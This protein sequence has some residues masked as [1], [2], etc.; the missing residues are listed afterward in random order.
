MS[1]NKTAVIKVR[2][3]RKKTK[4]FDKVEFTHL[5]YLKIRKWFIT[6]TFINKFFLNENFDRSEINLLK[7]II[8]QDPIKIHDIILETYSKSLNKNTFIFTLVLLSNGSF[9]SKRIFKSL[10]NKIIISPKELYRFMEF[11]KKE[12]GFGQVIHNAI[13]A[14]FKSYDV[15]NLEKMFIEHRSGYGWK[16]QDVIRLIRP[17]PTDHKERLLYNW[18]ANDNIKDYSIDERSYL[19]YVAAYEN[20]RNNKANEEKILEYIEKLN[21]KNSMIPGNVKRTKAILNSWINNSEDDI[22]ITI[23][24]RYLDS[25]NKQTFSNLSSFIALKPTIKK[26]SL[27][28]IM[29]TYLSLKE[30][31]HTAE[32]I[33]LLNETEN[34]LMNILKKTG[35][36]STLNLV[37]TSDDMFK[38]KVN[39]LSGSPA[40]VSSI[41]I[42]LGNSIDFQGNKI[43]K[44]N[45][46]SIIEAENHSSNI[47]RPNYS[48][49]MNVADENKDIDF[50]IVWSNKD[51][52]NKEVFTKFFDTWKNERKRIIKIVYIN[53]G[54]NT[55][56]HSND[57]KE[58]FAINDKTIKLLNYIKSGE[59]F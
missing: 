39:N 20:M 27:F 44:N 45:T 41:L 4:Q 50:I 34:T 19:P 35:D 48:K 6:G 31:A 8:L 15:N 51:V 24:P 21:F 29:A 16:S 38:G 7:S 33:D 55:K 12:R 53:L 47:I 40:I 9:E 46:R 11:C 14:W 5:E 1:D 36:K 54:M 57:T 28:T 52:V 30:E 17:K 18:I 3:V 37:D 22:P 59:I 23:I 26:I 42:G 13:K 10:F 58:I 56:I 25:I 43:T 32:E 2:Y 49:I